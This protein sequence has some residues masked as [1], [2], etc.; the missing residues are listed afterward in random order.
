MYTPCLPL[1]SSNL[2]VHAVGQY[3]KP[4]AS[5]PKSTGGR[6]E[7][8]LRCHSFTTNGN[9]KRIQCDQISY[10]KYDL[11]LP[12]LRILPPKPVGKATCFLDK[13]TYW[14]WTG[15]KEVVEYVAGCSFEKY[16]RLFLADIWSLLFCVLQ[17]WS[18]KP[19]RLYPSC[20]GLGWE[21]FIFDNQWLEYLTKYK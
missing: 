20:C 6:R 7:R 3:T 10:R 17:F 16:T 12:R 18:G 19:C 13:K 15:T 21:L 4:F 1:T 8:D 5:T 2:Y 14:H 9:R 11:L